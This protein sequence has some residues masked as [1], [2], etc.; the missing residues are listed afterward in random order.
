MRKIPPKQRHV[1]RVHIPSERKE[2][3]EAGNHPQKQAHRQ[4]ACNRH[5]RLRKME[6]QS[7]DQAYAACK[8]DPR[9]GSEQAI[10]PPRCRNEE[11]RIQ[12][13]A[14]RQDAHQKRTGF[15]KIE[16]RVP[17]SGIKCR[18]RQRNC[19]RLV[20]ESI[21]PRKLPRRGHKNRRPGGIA[22]DCACF[23]RPNSLETAW[24]DRRFSAVTDLSYTSPASSR[25]CHK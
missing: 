9:Q 15:A 14:Q 20:T 1:I 21:T 3:R 19:R 13:N 10:F 6:Q 2:K 24:P 18:P 11:S 17:T 22:L 25:G 4:R 8:A 5:P 23:S 12:Q 7:T 16:K